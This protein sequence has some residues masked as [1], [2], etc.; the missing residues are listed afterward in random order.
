M[1]VGLA[2]TSSMAKRL[3]REASVE[4]R[5]GVQVTDLLSRDGAVIGVK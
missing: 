1:N 4:V 3:E 2:I 5:T